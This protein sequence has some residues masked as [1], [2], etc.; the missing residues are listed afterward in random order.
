[1]LRLQ[2]F[3][4][5]KPTL[6]SWN[7]AK[8]ELIRYF[9]P[10]PM[11]TLQKLSKLRQ[12]T[13]T[14]ETYFTKFSALALGMPSRSANQ[15]NMIGQFFLEGLN[16]PLQLHVANRCPAS[17][18]DY[19]AMYEC[20]QGLE[21][22]RSTFISSTHSPPS[23]TKRVHSVAAANDMRYVHEDDDDM[24]D[25]QQVH[26]L[27]GN[28]RPSQNGN[29]RISTSSS[30]TAFTDAQMRQLSSMISS[31]VVNRPQ[32]ALSPLLPT[33]Q[34][35][36]Q[37]QPIQLLTRQNSQNQ[38][39]QSPSRTDRSPVPVNTSQRIFKST[40]APT[41]N[42]SYG[43]VRLVGDAMQQLQVEDQQ[44]DGR[45]FRGNNNNRN[46][47]QNGNRNGSNARKR[48]F[49]QV[50]GECSHSSD[51]CYALKNRDKP[52][53]DQSN[54]NYQNNSYRQPLRL[55]SN[56]SNQPDYS[57]QDQQQ[58]QISNTSTQ[59]LPSQMSRLSFTPQQSYSTQSMHP[60][61]Q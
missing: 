42:L 36:T 24:S 47:N 59:S 40:P 46:Y 1:M 19:K 16:E 30:N 48:Y 43:D 10:D 38:Q 18:H 53:Q 28:S 57:N 55:Q 41:R 26:F 44:Q 21:N 34:I 15:P 31:M 3:Q 49:C 9:Q 25:S 17:T 11:L 29:P 52:R 13:D 12:G 5:I 6:L 58:Q 60:N 61:F 35:S 54:Q 39:F 8:A 32:V 56:Y 37:S 50:H 20:A 23:P 27:Y 2:N 33:P 22:L 14:I 51:Y 45:N 7:H 4:D